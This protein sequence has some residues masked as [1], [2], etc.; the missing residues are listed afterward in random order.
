MAIIVGVARESAVGERRVALTPETCKKLI[1][2]GAQ[3]RVERGAGRGASFSDDAYAAAGALLVDSAGA[4][5]EE[6]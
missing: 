6:A 2:A 5:L 3:V 4:A 1:A